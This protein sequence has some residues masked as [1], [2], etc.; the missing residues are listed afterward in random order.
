M[1]ISTED[2]STVFEKFVRGDAA[3]VTNAKG[4]GL[5]LAMVRK[6]LEDQG[7]SIQLQ[8]TL[9]QGSTFTIILSQANLS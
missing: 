6:T 2:Q 7:A 4:T 9:G 8:S 3:R 5:G 1:G